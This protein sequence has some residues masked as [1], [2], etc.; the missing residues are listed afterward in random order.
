MSYYIA[1]LLASTIGF[2]LFYK[3]WTVYPWRGKKYAL[4]VFP[5]TLLFS[6]VVNIYVKQPSYAYILDKL[7]ISGSI[8]Y[9]PLWF[10]FFGIGIGAFWEE[11]IKILPAV[12][13]KYAVKEKIDV[14]YLSLFCGLGFGIGEALFLAERMAGYYPN[15]APYG[16][17]AAQIILS[18][19]GERLFSIIFHIV[20]TGIAGYG[21][22]VNK[23]L[24]FFLLAVFCHTMTNFPIG[25]YQKG[26]MSIPA[27]LIGVNTGMAIFY[28]LMFYLFFAKIDLSLKSAFRKAMVDKIDKVTL[29]KREGW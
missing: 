9:W 17:G 1:A 16:T 5:L 20:A 26:L 21:I 23:P 7:D 18:S 3:L 11:L 6:V 28:G 24:R 22:A 10:L 4:F 25:L 14:Y 12:I 15:Y 29:F 8:R 13:D 2:L 27:V 19:G